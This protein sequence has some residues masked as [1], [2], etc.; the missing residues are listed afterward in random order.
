MQTT[1]IQKIL[2]LTALTIILTFAVA[3]ISFAAPAN[4]A[5][6]SGI[7]PLTGE[8]SAPAGLKCPRV[9]QEAS[10]AVPLAASNCDG[11][12]QRARRGNGGNGSGNRKG[13][14]NG[15]RSRNG[16]GNGNRQGGNR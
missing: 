9:S 6:G 13:N 10:L 14:G 2:G 3:A 15:Q 4:P 7:C 8:V 16:S 1:T 5:P 12:Q 11:S